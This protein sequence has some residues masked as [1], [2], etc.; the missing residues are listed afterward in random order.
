MPRT[1]A[2]FVL[3]F[4]SC[5]HTAFGQES[6]SLVTPIHAQAPVVVEISTEDFVNIGS[7]LEYFEDVDDKFSLKDVRQFKKHLWTLSDSE[8]PNFGYT[9]SSYWFRFRLNKV[10]ECC[11]AQNQG[12]II[13]VEYA[14]LDHIEFYEIN[15]GEL[16]NE[17]VTGD[18]YPFTQR[19][20]P[21]RDFLFPVSL[22]FNQP[23]DIYFK[24]RT[25]GSTQFPIAIWDAQKFSFVDQNEQVIKTLYYGMLLALVF[26]NLFL[27]ISIKERPY[28]YYVG[29]MA[30]VLLL[31]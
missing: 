11:D 19:P 30:S 2:F 9:N 16:V 3:I 18:T 22:T 12:E 5:L 4:I 23:V 14:L 29:M 1:L 17:V 27:F 31:M 13:A 8:V 26:Y 10:L 6:V 15:K 28:I 20:L 21:H 7:K 25:Q 24:I